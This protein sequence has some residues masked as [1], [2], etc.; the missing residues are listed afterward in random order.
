MRM[1]SVIPAGCTR[2]SSGSRAFPSGAAVTWIAP[3]SRTQAIASSVCRRSSTNWN[4]SAWRLE[5]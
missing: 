5:R 3:G 2:L 4:A 1:A